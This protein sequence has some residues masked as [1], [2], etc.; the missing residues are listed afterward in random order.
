VAEITILFF[1]DVNGREIIYRWLFAFFQTLDAHRLF[2]VPES[3]FDF[4]CWV[5]SFIKKSKGL[6]K[7]TNPLISLLVIPGGIEPPLPA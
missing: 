7:F 1:G 5:W 2:T 6:A 3:H 4:G